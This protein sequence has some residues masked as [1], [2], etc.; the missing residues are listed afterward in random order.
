MTPALLAALTGC[1]S[2]PDADA[3]ALRTS[4]IESVRRA[5]DDE[6]TRSVAAA[7]ASPSTELGLSDQ[8]LSELAEISGPSSYRD[9]TPDFGP[10][11]LGFE[12]PT[13]PITLAEAVAAAIERDT[14]IRSAKLR[15]AI[16][17]SQLIQAE[18]AFDWVLF[19]NVDRS[20]TDRERPA[21]AIGDTPL[22]TVLD[23][24]DSV[25]A[26]TGVRKLLST[27]GT[28]EVG[29]S[30]DVFNN[31]TPG[32][33]RVPD[34]A[35]T[36]SLDLIFNQPL[37]RGFGP[38]V[39][40]AEVRLAENEDERALEDAR[41]TLID[42]ITEV[43]RSYWT[44]HYFRERLLVQQR[45]LARGIET[46]DALR[47]RYGFD[48]TDAELADAAARVESRRADLIR[49]QTDVRNES[50]RLKRLINDP[51]RPLMNE[52]V[53]VATDSPMSVG[54]SFDLEEA[55]AGALHRRPDV[56]RAL[57]DVRDQA[58]RE[59]VAENA[60]LPQLD[61]SL[62]LSSIGLDR[63][64]G[65]AFDETFDADYVESS[66]ALAF[67]LPIGNREAE[68][69]R[70]AARLRSM[71]ATL[72][73][74]TVARRAIEDVKQTLRTLTANH[75]LIEQTRIARI[76]AAENLRALQVEEETVRGLTPEFLDLKLNRQ[77]ALARAELEEAVVRA[78]YARSIADAMRAQGIT[79][80]Q[81][82][83]QLDA[84][85]L[86][87]RADRLLEFGANP[88]G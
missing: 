58:V 53:L 51:N 81:T 77:E 50:D 38:V 1:S 40:L 68:E 32:L 19:A 62:R 12:S 43:D 33:T 4:V 15:P 71:Q 42:T 20:I 59:G 29:A 84:D 28:F 83:L 76:A 41:E 48:V 66:I 47:G 56:R 69:G 17:R 65:D 10:D 8:R 18:A 45:L 13:E 37:L 23:R 70:R 36:A 39:A 88:D 61:L 22:G 24:S 52:T 67:E 82:G 57:I 21:T 49:A 14:T 80:E 30:L 27:G 87:D 11:L 72:D 73:Y 2:L 44:L 26:D 75:R 16:T 3:E 60:V 35:R 25:T 55:I 63:N 79:L 74:R 5:L 46:R 64:E 9:D 86:N 34:P 7:P 31:A 85:A 54:L 78:D 6:P